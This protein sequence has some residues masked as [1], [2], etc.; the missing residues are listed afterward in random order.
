MRVGHLGFKQTSSVDREVYIPAK[1][2]PSREW[3][4]RANSMPRITKLG[5]MSDRST[6]VAFPRLGTTMNASTACR[7]AQR[8]VSPAAGDLRVVV[9]RRLRRG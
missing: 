1:L 8:R 9:I 4:V 6:K 2:T 3:V 7:I 5:L